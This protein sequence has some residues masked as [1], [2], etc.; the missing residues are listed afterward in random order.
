M[1]LLFAGYLEDMIMV[2]VHKA[3][4]YF[5]MRG[6]LPL[7]QG[8]PLQQLMQPQQ[9]HHRLYPMGDQLQI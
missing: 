8:L 6:M 4:L 1:Q 5:L 7:R 9:Q 2:P 3:R